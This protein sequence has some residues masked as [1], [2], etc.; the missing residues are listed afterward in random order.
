MIKKLF[1]LLTHG[2]YTP[3]ELKKVE[4]SI[5][6]ANRKSLFIFGALSCASTFAGSMGGL[7]SDIAVMKQSLVGYLV[8]F[9]LNLAAIV[10]NY[11]TK[12]P[13]RARQSAVISLYV[14]PLYLF[15]LYQAIFISPNDRPLILVVF[16][17]LIPTI[18]IDAPIRLYLDFIGTAIIYLVVSPHIVP[19]EQIGIDIADILIFGTAGVGI[20][21]FFNKSRT[22]RYVLAIRLEEMRS[23]GEQMKYWKS[24]SDIY[25][26]MDQIDLANDTY[27]Q[28]RSTKLID[29]AHENNVGYSKAV[30]D[31]MKASVDP[32]YLEAVLAFVDPKTLEERLGDEN[33]IT[34]EFLGKN[35]GWCRARYIAVNKKEGEPLT[36]A[37]FLVENINEQK[38]REKLLTTI[39]ETDGMTGLYNRRAGIP[40]IKKQLGLNN[41]GMLCLLD[42]DK[43][44]HINDNYGHQAGDRVI[45]AVA[46][47]LRETFRDVDIILRL[48]GDEFL[49]YISNVDTEQIGSNVFNRLFKN[50]E[51]V[52]ISSIPDYKISISIGATFF[53]EGCT[54]DELYSQAD[55]STYESK[56]VNGKAFTFFRG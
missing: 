37:M 46:D 50:F 38:K 24:I 26:S 28:I 3:E 5:F 10:L 32:D 17:C 12:K 36:Q 31:V 56:K 25:L 41:H 23:E 30:S 40:K 43:F 33:T 11:F 42:V 47:T 44:K 6:T 8:V 1:G 45:I 19:A 13:S 2:H 35:Y 14:I 20:G 54:F 15:A 22:E 53:K 16:L 52:S 48:G 39:A 34:Y 9:F 29:A 18:F 49:F 55:C 51:R 4:P 7:F 21:L 27:L